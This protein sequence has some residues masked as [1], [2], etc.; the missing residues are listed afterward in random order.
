MQVNKLGDF[1][2]KVDS[3]QEPIKELLLLTYSYAPN[4]ND[5]FYLE[6]TIKSYSNYVTDAKG[7]YPSISSTDVR[8]RE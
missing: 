1:Y 4:V 7:P 8:G 6:V 3:F 5:I 2:L